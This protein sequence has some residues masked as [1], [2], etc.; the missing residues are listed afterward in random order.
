MLSPSLLYLSIANIVILSVSVWLFVDNREDEVTKTEQIEELADQSKQIKESNNNEKEEAEVTLLI[1]SNDS[2]TDEIAKEQVSA[3]EKEAAIIKQKNDLLAKQKKQTELLAA[4]IAENKHLEDETSSLQNQV[5]IKDT[6]LNESLQ[7][8]KRLKELLSQEVLEK[9]RL[10]YAAS[11]DS[12]IDNIKESIEERPDLLK[13]TSVN[14]SV[15][16]PEH[17]EGAIG[18]ESYVSIDPEPAIEIE[19]IETDVVS[20][21][22]EEET[23][24]IDNFTGAVEFG[25]NYEQDNQVTTNVDGR[26]ILDYNVVDQYNVNSDL[27]FEFEKEDGERNTEKYRWQLQWT[28]NLDP[29]NVIVTRSDIQR[30]QYASYDKEDTYSIG[31]GRIFFNENNH[32]FNAEIGPGYRFAVPNIGEDAVAV[33]EFILRTLLNYERIVSENLQLSTEAVL[34]TGKENSVYTVEL[35]AQNRIYKELYLVFKFNY[36]YNQNVPVDN[37]HS[38]TS[39]GMSFLYAF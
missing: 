5:N 18:S 31:Y 17:K 26:F 36:K 2:V 11:L 39:T 14:K 22:E 35:A 9:K 23:Y 7:R 20:S 16:S 29:K 28:H 34:E 25:F 8:E 38:E 37:V 30:S 3:S 21:Q 27:D 6:Y 10:Q 4:L 24:F 32:K 15:T 33:N 1:D 12:P 13:N 19:L